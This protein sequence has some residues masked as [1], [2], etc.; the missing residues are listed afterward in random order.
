MRFSV[1]RGMERKSHGILRVE[2]GIG[3]VPGPAGPDARFQ[4]VIARPH[5][6]SMA[7]SFRKA[8]IEIVAHAAPGMRMRVVHTLT[9]EGLTLGKYEAH[10]L[11]GSADARV[12]M[13]VS[14]NSS[15]EALTGQLE[16]IA[17]VVRIIAFRP[18]WDQTVAVPSI[19][20]V[21]AGAAPRTWVAWW[22]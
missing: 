3:A 4:E 18:S 1:A 22:Y 17:G 20:P 8:E 6:R 12:V 21:A 10:P 14:G 11:P 15:V 5:N 2:L 19:G 13:D 7:Q 16:K 9:A